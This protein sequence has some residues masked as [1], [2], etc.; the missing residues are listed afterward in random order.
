[1]A[2]VLSKLVS[3]TSLDLQCTWNVEWVVLCAACA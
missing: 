3:L 2:G 1:M